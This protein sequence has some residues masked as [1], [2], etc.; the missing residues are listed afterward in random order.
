MYFICS[1]QGFDLAWLSHPIKLY[2]IYHITT[3]FDDYFFQFLRKYK[4]LS[5]NFLS[6]LIADK[7]RKNNIFY[8]TRRS[9]M[10]HKNI[11]PKYFM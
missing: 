3:Y 1:V 11:S 10:K 4:I 7:I 2:N 8:K 6:I 9:E 5:A